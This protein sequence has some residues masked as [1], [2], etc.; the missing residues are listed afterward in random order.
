M[1]NKYTHIGK[2]KKDFVQSMFD[3]ISFKYDIFNHLATFY[4]DKYWRYQFIKRLDIK[5]QMNILDIATGTGDVIIKICS[6]NKNSNGIGFDCSQ[7][8]LQIAKNKSKIKKIRNVKYIHGYAEKLP[9]ESNSIDIITISFGIRNFN[10]YEDALEEINRVLKPNG[11]LAILEFCR[12]KNNFFQK[13][14]SFYFNNIIPIIGKIL[15]G[16]KLFDY[17]PESVNNFFS[18]NELSEKIENFGFKRKYSKNLTF[19]ICSIIIGN[20]TNEGNQ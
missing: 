8:M 7:N 14:F 6:K 13:I 19:G 11:T 4:I 18:K 16:E 5:K 20:K 15:T 12:P 1:D 9:F 3:K 10:N 17:L 2:D